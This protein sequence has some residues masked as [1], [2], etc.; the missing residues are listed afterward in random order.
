MNQITELLTLLKVI[1]FRDIG[2]RSKVWTEAD[3]LDAAAYE[4]A[5]VNISALLNFFRLSHC[6]S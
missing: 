3:M 6:R 4:F 5:E 2:P 1:Y